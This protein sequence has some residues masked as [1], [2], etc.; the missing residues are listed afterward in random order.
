[1]GEGVLEYL[2]VVIWIIFV[3]NKTESKIEIISNESIDYLRTNNLKL[4]NLDGCSFLK[5]KEI[6]IYC[7]RVFYIIKIVASVLFIASL[8]IILNKISKYPQ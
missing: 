4:S 1:M 7:I 5:A 2:S 8:N 6:K 3:K